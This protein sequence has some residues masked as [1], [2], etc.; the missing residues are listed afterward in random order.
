M[1]TA[2][3]LVSGSVA[4]WAQIGVTIAA[5][6]V[7]VPIYL[8]HWNVK[9][10]GVWLAVQGILSALSMLDMGYQSYLGFEFLRL[11][12]KNLLLLSKSLWSAMLV[13]ILISLVQITIMVIFVFT[14]ALPFLLGEAGTQDYELIH[15]A[16]VSL[17]LQGITWLII[18]TIP[19]L[20]VKA[21]A[22]FGYFPRTAW[23]GF[24]YALTIAFAPLIAVIYG[25]DLL[26]ASIS[27]FIG[28]MLC[29]LGLYI[30]L[31]RLLKKEKIRFLKPSFSL[32][33][34]NFKLSLPLLGKSLLENVRQQGV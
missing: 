12:K 29:G 14:D 32:G 16:G 13:G 27:L 24:A 10:Y 20:M 22:A 11:G 7:L 9:T 30:D 5:Q 21:L 31:I 33:F 23:W 6:V 1:S 15:A 25:G 34:S 26:M 19:G 4:S 18:M 2:A 3:R 28:A 8:S 17:I